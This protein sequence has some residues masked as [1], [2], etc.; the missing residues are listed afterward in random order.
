MFRRDLQRQA[1]AD[2]RPNRRLAAV[3]AV[4]VA[5]LALVGTYAAHWGAG[6]LSRLATLCVTGAMQVRPQTVWQSWSLSP[7]SLIPLALLP[8]ALHAWRRGTARA[9]GVSDADA[10]RWQRIALVAG[11][12]VL[13]VALVSPLCRLA[14]TL[15]SAHMVQHLLLVIVAPA[16]LAL[17]R[18]APVARDAIGPIAI[19]YG[20]AI[21][22]WHAPPVYTAVVSREAAHVVGYALLIWIGVAF[23]S[24]MLRGP[25][26]AR[27]KAALAMLATA[28]HT[29]LL[30]ALL[31]FAPWLLYP[32]LAPGA[33]PWGMEPLQDQQLAGLLMWIVGGV[34]YMAA[35]LMLGVRALELRAA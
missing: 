4:P 32:V 3:A 5:L 2:P 35:G 1:P 20:L 8:M 11:W 19:V 21:W 29:T 28:L 10:Q 17:S 15:V 12:L 34:A 31:A 26:P 14:A 33:P 23:W 24:Q 13:A 27:A 7:W 30:G 9:I 18:P 6:E 22:V 25:Q 16:L